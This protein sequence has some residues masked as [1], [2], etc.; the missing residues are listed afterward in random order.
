MSERLD[1]EPIHSLPARG[2]DVAFYFYES[3]IHDRTLRL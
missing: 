1:G 2:R 3:P